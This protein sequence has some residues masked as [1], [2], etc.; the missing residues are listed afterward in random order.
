MVG[1][2]RLDRVSRV[3]WIDLR[4]DNSLFLSVGGCFMA[5]GGQDAV[6]REERN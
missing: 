6:V 2:L 3:G 4:I 5:A 1:F